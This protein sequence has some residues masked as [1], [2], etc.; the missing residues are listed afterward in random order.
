MG[1]VDDPHFLAG[2]LRPIFWLLVM[3]PLLALLRWALN[4]YVRP[5]L[6]PSAWAVSQRP[7]KVNDNAL[8]AVVVVLALIAALG[9]LN[10]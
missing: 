4:R 2:L 5:R 10:Q 9:L 8:V 1:A 7:V 6:K 3:L